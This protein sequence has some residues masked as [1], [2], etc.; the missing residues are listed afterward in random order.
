MRLVFAHDHIFYKHE[1]RYY[2]T[3]GLSS[4]VLQ[5]YTNVFKEVVILSRQKEIDVYQDN[6]TLASTPGVRFVEVPNFKNWKNL[7]QIISAKEVIRK[8]VLSAD[9]LIA[10]L[11]SSIGNLAVKEAIKQ[12]VPYLLEVVACPWDSLWN[13]SNLG[14]VIAPFSYSRMKKN[15]KK[16]PYVLYVTSEF[17]QRR[18][19]TEGISTNCSNVNLNLIHQETQKERL[20][21]IETSDGKIVLG[22]TAALNVKSKGQQYIIK[23]LSKLKEKGIT[24]YEYQLV[25][26]GD[27][28]Y[29]KTIAEKYNVR[30]Q[31][32]FIGPLKH[33]KVFEWLQD[34]DIY[35]QPSRQEGLPRAL[36][37]AMS[38]ALPAFGANTAGIPELLDKEFIFRNTSYNFDEILDILLKL[39]DKKVLKEQSKRNFLESK[40][41]QFDVLG[42]RRNDFFKDFKNYSS[43]RKKKD[44]I[45]D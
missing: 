41:Y 20:K 33:N 7:N 38:M 22:T 15:V 39:N 1:E 14:K 36:V 21:R 37:E 12:D 5:R 3:G 17:L 32:K 44:E 11:P 24:N 27:N 34:V 23:A 4:D 19:P 16:A 35:I 30:N 8:E 25:G 29:L 18:Y 9:S 45:N 42:K 10:R 26:A 43:I 28:S 40:K 13:H 2:S 31:V 6:L